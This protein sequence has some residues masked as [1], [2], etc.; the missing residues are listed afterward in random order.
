MGFFSWRGWDEAVKQYTMRDVTKLAETCISLGKSARPE[1]LWLKSRYDHVR[2]RYHLRNKTETD[3]FLYERMYGSAPERE[4]EYLK[5]RYWRTG[6]YMPGNRNQ[7]MLFGKALDLSEA[8]MEFL[9]Q[10]YCDRGIEAYDPAVCRGDRSYRERIKY[11]KEIIEAYLRNM[12]KQRLEK[13]HIPERKTEV[14]LRHLYFTD[15]LY[16]VA[17]PGEISQEVISKHITSLRYESEFSRQMRLYGEIPRR[18]F[19]R[20]MLIMGMP[21]MT[22]DRLNEQLEFFGYL[23]LDEEHTMVRGE[24]LDWLLIRLMG[25]YEEMR[26]K[27]G[28]EDAFLWFQ[29]ACRT[30]DAVFRKEGCPKLRFMHFKALDL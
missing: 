12:P 4:S 9:I 15:A 29:K 17:A 7:C 26:C 22:L 30:L 11:L 19:I 27:K 24:R 8:D 23:A 13:L 25:M 1:L 28:D 5:I 20:H 18:V 3:K 6:K 10:Q 14:F 16:Y 2:S 21:D